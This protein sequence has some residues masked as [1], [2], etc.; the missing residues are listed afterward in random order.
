MPYHFEKK[1]GKE[2][3]LGVLENLSIL[4]DKRNKVLAGRK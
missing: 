3:S 2:T 4:N 1:V